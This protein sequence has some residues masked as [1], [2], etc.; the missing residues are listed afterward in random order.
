LNSTFFQ[1]GSLGFIAGFFAWFTW[2]FLVISNLVAYWLGYGYSNAMSGIFFQSRP[3]LLVVYS[4]LAASF[5]LGS[6]ACFGLKRKYGSS[7]ALICGLLY[8]AVF[9]MLCYS[10]VEVR[11]FRY[12]IP[13]FA[14]T[15]VLMNLGLLFWG[16]TLWEV[17]KSL[18]YPNLGFWTGSIFL[19]IA[20]LTLTLFWPVIL[21]WGIEFWFVFF[22]WLYAIG[23]LVTAILLFRLSKLCSR[24]TAVQGGNADLRSL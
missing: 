20:I 6:F 8:I 18:S 5:M 3:Y 17:R 1:I 11:L 13:M 14:T 15:L 12:S 10:V 2:F 16:A 19:V 21:Y 9:A 7:I 22:G 23:S 24:D 4:F